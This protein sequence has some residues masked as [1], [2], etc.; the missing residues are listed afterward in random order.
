[1]TSISEQEPELRNDNQ[2]QATEEST[3]HRQS[4]HRVVSMTEPEGT[5]SA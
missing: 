5:T 3:Q 2:I 4:P 1:M